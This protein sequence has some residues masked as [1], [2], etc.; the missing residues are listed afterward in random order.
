[1]LRQALY[2]VQEAFSAKPKHALSQLMHEI[3][4]EPHN[5]GQSIL[6]AVGLVAVCIS[7]LIWGGIRLMTATRPEPFYFS[8]KFYIGLG[9]LLCSL[10]WVSKILPG[11]LHIC[12][13]LVKYH[14]SKS[15]Q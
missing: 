4:L 2:D 15:L 1:M 13:V 6:L 5:L 11:L 3:P 10:A 14:Q 8:I 9:L 7:A 12:S